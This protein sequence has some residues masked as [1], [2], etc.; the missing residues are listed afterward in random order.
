MCQDDVT[1]F[2]SASLIPFRI[3]GTGHPFPANKRE[4]YKILNVRRR[5]GFSSAERAEPTRE[6]GGTKLIRMV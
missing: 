4:V 5:K 1:E 2:I 3:F 6:D